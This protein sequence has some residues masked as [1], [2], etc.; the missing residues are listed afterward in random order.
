MNAEAAPPAPYIARTGILSNL[1]LVWTLTWLNFLPRSPRD[2]MRL[3]WVFAEPAGQLAIMMVIFSLIGRVPSYGNSFAF[4]LLT[5]IAILTLFRNGTQASRM[6]VLG[7]SARNRLAHVG[8]FH[9]AI[10]RNLFN[11]IVAVIYTGVLAY[12]LSL[13]QDVEPVPPHPTR[14]AAA[15]FWCMLFGFGVGLLRA[16]AARFL[17]T[18]DRIYGIASRALLFISGVF[19]VPSFMVPQIRDYLAYNPVLQLIELFRLG[20]FDQYPTVVYAPDYLR[21][22]I[23]ITVGVGLAIVWSKRRSFLE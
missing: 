18:V 3:F 20:M 8:V 23:L 17:P 7:L 10:A 13:F 16:S 12:A 4:F 15:F 11:I 6:A 1:R 5:G 19:F 14:A 21:G 2:G 22:C 9:E